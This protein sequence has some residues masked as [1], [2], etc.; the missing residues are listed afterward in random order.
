M[1]HT[2]SSK[3]FDYW[4]EADITEPLN[5]ETMNL[6]IEYF[7]RYINFIKTQFVN[8]QLLGAIIHFDETNPHLHLHISS[9]NDETHKFDRRTFMSK[10]FLKQL[11]SAENKWIDNWI[12][13]HQQKYKKV[14]SIYEDKNLQNSLK[15][16]RQD[17]QQI[18]NDINAFKKITETS[19]NFKEVQNN[20]KE[21]KELN[22]ELKILKE[23]QAK[24]EQKLL[25]SEIATLT[26]IN[27]VILNI[28]YLRKQVLQ[29]LQE[30]ENELN[31]IMNKLS[32]EQLNYLSTQNTNLSVRAYIKN[33]IK[34][35]EENKDISNNLYFRK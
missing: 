35:K 34:N 32:L 11:K 31:N 2:I 25:I 23:A 19:S 13:N 29:S 18:K 20:L 21:L 10:D 28:I 4:K 24:Q 14:D 27:C 26:E 22:S 8:H 9:Y 16:L 30:K 1:I 3:E 15:E 6:I 17:K 5:D 12:Q 7:T 33:V